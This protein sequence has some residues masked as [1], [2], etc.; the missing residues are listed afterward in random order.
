MFDSLF[1]RIT[2]AHLS[3]GCKLWSLVLLSQLVARPQPVAHRQFYPSVDPKL[4]SADRVGDCRSQFRCCALSLPLLCWDVRS[5]FP[6]PR[7][8]CVHRTMVLILVW[9][10]KQFPELWDSQV[11]ATYQPSQPINQCHLHSPSTNVYGE[12]IK[13]SSFN[14]VPRVAYT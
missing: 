4:R 1:Q 5:T 14:T 2:R 3:I 6:A 10:W 9:I 7:C 8:R 11:A 13:L 12:E